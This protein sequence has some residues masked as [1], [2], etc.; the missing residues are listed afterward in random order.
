MLNALL[1]VPGGGGGGGGGGGAFLFSGKSSLS[2]QIT[3]FLIL[4]GN[5]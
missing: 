1:T 4:P 5:T 2:L 3:I